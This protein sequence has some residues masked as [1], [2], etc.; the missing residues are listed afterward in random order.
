MTRTIFSTT[1]TRWIDGI[2]WEA[3]TRRAGGLAGL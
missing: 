3:M 2:H 1:L